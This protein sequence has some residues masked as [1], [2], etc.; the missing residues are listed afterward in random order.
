MACL[1][2]RNVKSMADCIRLEIECAEIC[3]TAASFMSR[4]SRFA[5]DVCRVC[6]EI[7]EACGAECD[8]FGDMDHCRRC[9]EACHQCAEECRHMAAVAV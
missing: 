6:A 3:R 1:D 4:G 2:A 5:H 8:K 9:A 7:C